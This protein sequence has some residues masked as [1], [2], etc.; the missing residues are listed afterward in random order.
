MKSPIVLLESLLIDIKRLEPDVEGLD[1]DIITIRGRYEHEGTGFLTVTL[2]N[3]CDSLDQGLST[4][5]FTS[6]PGLKKLRKKAI[7]RLFSGMLCK[8]FDT[9]TGLLIE[10]PSLSVVKLLREVLRLFKKLT[11]ASDREEV[12][13][14][15][16]KAEFVEC[17]A[18]CITSNPFDER[19][20]YLLDYVS[21]C[22]LPNI[23][24]FDERELP[25]K[26]GP[27]AVFEKISGNRKW[28]ALLTYSSKLE[29]LGFDCVYSSNGDT[30]LK[31]DSAIL[32]EYGVSGDTARLI[33]VPKNST[34]RRTITV[35]PI[36]RQYVQQGFNTLLRDNISRCGVLKRCLALTD[37]TLNSNLALV[38]SRT[39]E[40]ATI[41]LKSAS[42]LLSLWLVERIFRFR[43]SFLSGILSCRS[44][45]VNV[46]VLD[47]T[48]RKYAGMGNATTF[49]V[50]SVVFAV[51]AITALLDG[52]RPSYRN[53]QRVASTIRIYGDDI[54]VPTSGARQVVDWITK[55]GLTV[56]LRKSFLVGNFKESCGIDAYRG[57]NITPLYLRHCPV[58]LSLKEP[59]VVSHLVSFANQAWLRGL[60]TMSN[61]V[62]EFVDR[63]FKKPLPLVS[64]NSG[65]LGWHSR[66]DYQ[67]S[68]RWNSDLHR[69]ETYGPVLVP[70]KR[71]DKLSDYAALLKFY[72]VPLLGRDND[73]LEKT[74]MRYKSRIVMRWVPA[75]AG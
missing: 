4:G 16:A 67:E 36:V 55:A 63:G 38:S 3:L 68:H 45:K 34:S 71:K 28:S 51:L 30:R 10:T 43:P 11:L 9:E 12:L 15:K 46:G 59:N 1:R 65:M 61:T 21:R 64:Q 2:P 41:D 73:H 7:P 48:L 47:I 70:L 53:V 26:H 49:P 35:E 31:V 33:T 24:S 8:V 39:G 14:Q 18:S 50:Q 19:E 54:I 37:Q 27:G 74:P 75:Y 44:P 58:S 13:D 25:C 62:R 66:V 17:D 42:D 56:N 20:T 69:F 32:N 5:W 23:E 6:P 72:H 22:V 40:F 60:Y 57:V 29:E 52:K